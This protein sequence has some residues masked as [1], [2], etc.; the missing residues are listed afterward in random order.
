[1]WHLALAK[2][3]E[4]TM[5]VFV[6]EVLNVLKDGAW[7]STQELTTSHTPEQQQ[8]ILEF[9]V[10]YKFIIVQRISDCVISHAKL[11]NSMYKFLWKLE[12]LEVSS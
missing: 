9:L 4:K 6:D 2:K 10:E 7:H 1:V 12:K 3:K 11:T 8:F 5:T